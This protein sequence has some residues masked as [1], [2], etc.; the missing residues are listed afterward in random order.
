MRL[1]GA[2]WTIALVLGWGASASAHGGVQDMH[3]FFGTLLFQRMM[4]GA[5]ATGGIIATLFAL[6]RRAERRVRASAG[7]SV[8]G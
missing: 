7:R 5:I 4:W 8:R 1:R 2:L 6:S 3:G